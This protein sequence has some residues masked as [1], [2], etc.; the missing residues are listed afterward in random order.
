MKYIIATHGYLADGFASSIKILSGKKDIY[1]INAYV[2]SSLN[3]DI[4]VQFLE[5]LKTFDKDEKIVIFT[6]IM[7]G[8]VTQIVTNLIK[9]YNIIGFTG[10]NLALIME[11]IMY[12]GKLTNE[13]INN[14]IEES[15]N[16]IIHLNQLV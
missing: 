8:S 12:Q 3:V 15:K 2:D 1:T 4:S 13:V 11:V 5:I 16:Q 10:V 7:G 14:I 9:D 6:D